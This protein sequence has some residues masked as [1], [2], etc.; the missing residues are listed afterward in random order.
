LKK[1]TEQVVQKSTKFFIKY[2]H[3][4]PVVGSI[5]TA[6]ASRTRKLTR[7]DD[8]TDIVSD[9]KTL[10]EETYEPEESSKLKKK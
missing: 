9:F 3:K 5:P 8:R 6:I 4:L 10:V 7:K 2:F 1:L